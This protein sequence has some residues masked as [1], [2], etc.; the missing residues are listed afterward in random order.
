MGE[1][2]AALSVTKDQV[3]QIIKCFQI[4][5]CYKSWVQEALGCAVHCGDVVRRVENGGVEGEGFEPERIG[6]VG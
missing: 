4:I 2:V 1:G 3:I 6:A 5:K